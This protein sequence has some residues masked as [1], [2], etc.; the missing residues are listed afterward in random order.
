MSLVYFQISGILWSEE[1]KELISG[2]G[3]SE[4]QL[5]IWKYP[6]MNIVTQLTGL[7]YLYIND[8]Q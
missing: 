1:H 3:F 7:K 8:G 6:S 5:T 2:H 4:N